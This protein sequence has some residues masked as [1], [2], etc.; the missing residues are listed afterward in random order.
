MSQA[1][2]ATAGMATSPVPQHSSAPVL[3]RET[4]TLQKAGARRGHDDVWQ[5]S[6]GWLWGIWDQSHAKG[7]QQLGCH[8]PSLPTG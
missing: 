6:A 5:L 1:A 7:L 3:G 4:Q 2:A 8:C